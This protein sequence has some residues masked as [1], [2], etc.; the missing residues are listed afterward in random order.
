[1]N[2]DEQI[3]VLTRI[4]MLRYGRPRYQE[5]VCAVAARVDVFLLGL[6]LS[7]EER[8]N[9]AAAMAQSLFGPAFLATTDGQR[10]AWVD[11]CERALLDVETTRRR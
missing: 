11:M 6:P 3:E 9:R 2:R 1:M 4:E 7:D 10:W 8:I 5:D